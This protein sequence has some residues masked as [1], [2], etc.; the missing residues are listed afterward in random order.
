M[1]FFP[2]SPFC[3]CCILD[4]LG[5][6]L[7]FKTSKKPMLI[8]GIVISILTS[9]WEKSLNR[10]TEVKTKLLYFVSLFPICKVHCYLM[11][12]CLKIS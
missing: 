3:I 8:N 1:L 11:R 9:S 10:D 2:L 4:I 12:F 7:I 6:F 5:L